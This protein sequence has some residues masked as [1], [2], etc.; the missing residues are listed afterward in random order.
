MV[1]GS[2][3]GLDTVF[4][5]GSFRGLDTFCIPARSLSKRYSRLQRLTRGLGHSADE[6][7]AHYVRSIVVQGSLA[8]CDAVNA[9]GS[10]SFYDAVEYLDSLDAKDTF[11]VL[12]SL[13]WHGAVAL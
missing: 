9:L 11:V 7:L 6:R 4:V 8:V 12:D 1:F 2:L 10:F 13:V 5:Q 3:E